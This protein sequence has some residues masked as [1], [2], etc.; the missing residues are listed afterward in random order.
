M[1]RLLA[2]L[3]LA[4]LAGPARAM[5]AD[6]VGLDGKDVKTSKGSFAVDFRVGATAR[7]RGCSSRARPPGY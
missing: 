2:I 3:A 4:I 7:A 6:V 1:G 5:T